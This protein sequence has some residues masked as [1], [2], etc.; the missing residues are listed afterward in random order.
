[1]EPQD[2]A[3]LEEP[4]TVPS[5]ELTP[6]HLEERWQVAWHT[7]LGTLS[8]TETGGVDLGGEAGRHHVEWQPPEGVGPR[9]VR[10]WVTVR[11]GRGGL[12][13]LTRRVRYTP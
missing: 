2:F 5:F 13:W 4:Y 6:V 7:S 1:M 10:F 3:H 12:S 9:D 11:D 8:P